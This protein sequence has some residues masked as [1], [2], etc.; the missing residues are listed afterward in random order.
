MTKRQYASHPYLHICNTPFDNVFFEIPPGIYL[1]DFT[2]DNL[3]KLKWLQL[4]QDGI[5][6]RLLMCEIIRLDAGVEL[7]GK[8]VDIDHD[9]G[10]WL[11]KMMLRQSKISLSSREKWDEDTVKR[12]RG[13][14]LAFPLFEAE[15][16]I[17]R[18][19]LARAEAVTVLAQIEIE[20]N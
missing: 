13:F 6:A 2:F 4:A 15:I 16:N 8:L 17:V 9:A 18:S 3:Q 12:W 10:L 5:D 20:E 7:L 19:A 14:S 1:P 11:L